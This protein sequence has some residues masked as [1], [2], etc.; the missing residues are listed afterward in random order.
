MRMITS[1]AFAAVL[2]VVAAPTLAGERYNLDPNHTQ[3]R[4]TWN[5]FGYS[6]MSAA[7]GE[8]KA[9]FELDTADLTQSSIAVEIPIESLAS[10]V[11]KLDAHLKSADFFNSAEFPTATFKSTAVEKV[12]D[13][14]LKVAGDLTIHGV[15]RPAVLAVTVNQI[16]THPMANDPAAGFDATTTIKR[17]EFGIDKYAPAVSDEIHIQIST[18]THKAK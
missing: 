2:A 5:H 16:G 4:F 3:V 6:N 18:E 15:T 17:S 1:L 14:S 12:G 10:G 8:V 11:P 9:E 13:K 7:F